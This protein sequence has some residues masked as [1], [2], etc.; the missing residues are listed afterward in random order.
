MEKKRQNNPQGDDNPVQPRAGDTAPK[1]RAQRYNRLAVVALVG[2]AVGRSAPLLAAG[3]SVNA[4]LTGTDGS[5]P[6]VRALDQRYD[7]NLSHQAALTSLMRLSGAM[8]YSRTVSDGDTRQVLAPSLDATL[9]NKLFALALQGTADKTITEGEAATETYTWEASFR[10]KQTAFPVP[11]L[12]LF[13]G[14]TWAKDSDTPSRQDSRA[15]HAGGNAAWRM[16]VGDLR[17]DFRLA[18]TTDRVTDHTGRNRQ[19][20]AAFTT[21]RA[22]F[23][24]RLTL[25]LNQQF[26]RTTT[27]HTAPTDLFGQALL[28]VTLSAVQ[29]GT[30]P[31]DPTVSLPTVPALHDG[32]LQTT[33]FSLPVLPA[34]AS[35]IV[36]RTDYR[37]VDTL[38]LSTVDDISTL[39]GNLAFAL[40]ASDNGSTWSLIDPAVPLSYDASKQRLIIQAP[41]PSALFLK[42]IT[43]STP[44][45]EI[46]LAELTAWH[47]VLANSSATAT[48]KTW[49]ENVTTDVGAAVR[50]RPDL[51]LHYTL[52]YQKN[53]AESLPTYQRWQLSSGL[54]WN[55]RP[56]LDLDL[57]STALL[58]HHDGKSENL[59]RTYGGTFQWRPLDTLQVTGG[60]VFSE[61]FLAQYR[62]SHTTT[63]H[64]SAAADL[65]RDLASRL[66]YTRTVGN[67]DLTGG[68][69]TSDTVTAYF[70]ARLFPSLLADV[71]LD[72]RRTKGT[73]SSTANSARLALAWRPSAVFSL[74]SSLTGNWAESDTTTASL[75]V[76]LAMTSKTRLSA[77]WRG[78]LRP[79]FEESTRAIWYWTINDYL[80]LSCE[81]RVQDGPTSSWDLVVRLLASRQLP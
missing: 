61:T 59:V 65:Y 75:T 37:R 57:R 5:D 70:T 25:S 4:E 7:L 30:P 23:A 69:T 48:E 24:D 47:T 78:S 77:T 12:R 51:S 38:Y 58:Q 21:Q 34:T 32:D 71:N 81:G 76:D 11:T 14:Q 17:L 9:T 31:A 45:S 27:E 41:S 63:Y 68:K 56:D 29:A 2:L 40:Y 19:F 53:R 10:S 13:A 28:P 33:A 43:T 55:I 49:N 66:D 1:A 44:N 16:P 73:S 35:A 3:L 64:A 62:Q 79:T 74:R 52:S 80:R 8:R 39:A 36:L 42:L 72:H 18:R 22:F 26:S 67:N 20:Q 15:S 60:M 46:K 6:A 54:N 50:L